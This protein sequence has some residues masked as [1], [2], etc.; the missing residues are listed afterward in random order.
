MHK[1]CWGDAKDLLNARPRSFFEADSYIMMDWV[2]E[3]SERVR[4]FQNFIAHPGNS[5]HVDVFYQSQKRSIH[6]C[7]EQSHE[8]YGGIWSYS[9]LYK[10]RSHSKS[11]MPSAKIHAPG[12]SKNKT[13]IH[14]VLKISAASIFYFHGWAEQLW[15]AWNGS[16]I[17][18]GS[19]THFS[20]LLFPSISVLK[21]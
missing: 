5:K 13:S 6:V 4:I 7:R 9:A 1:R 3:C 12:I 2:S 19:W 17:R 8:A 20:K 18:T 11:A 10:I 14:N 21:E 15:K 16:K